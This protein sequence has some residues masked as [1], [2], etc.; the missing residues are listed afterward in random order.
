M[1]KR[2]RLQSALVSST[3]RKA[4]L[5]TRE[6]VFRCV[7]SAAKN[8]PHTVPAMVS[9]LGKRGNEVNAVTVNN[10]LRA[11]NRLGLC[12]V[13][14]SAPAEGRGRPAAIWGL[15]DAGQEVAALR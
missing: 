7:A 15:T 10:H 9:R 2:Q 11:L 12:E 8:A 1:N 5:A 13:V 4:D 6:Q 3:G 14:G